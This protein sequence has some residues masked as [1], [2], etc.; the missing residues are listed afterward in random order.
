MRDPCLITPT[1]C[2]QG[3][4]QL[5]A[6]SQAE[7][8]ALA[9]IARAALV[10]MQLLDMTPMAIDGMDVSTLIP[11]FDHLVSELRALRSRL[12][13]VLQVD[14]ERVAAATAKL[15]LPKV[16]SLAPDFPFS[17]LLEP[18]GDGLSWI[19]AE[20]AVTP[21]ISAIVAGMKRDA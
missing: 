11:F 1:S 17:E 3:L 8:N 20:R 15:I 10:P 21:Y 9:G 19:G 4:D 13:E 5:P 18:L 16:Y 2:A 7:A 14:G 12:D 6:L